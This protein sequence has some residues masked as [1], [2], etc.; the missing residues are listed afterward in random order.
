MKQIN[1]IVQ[2]IPGLSRNYIPCPG[3][4]REINYILCLGERGQNHTLSRGT[5]PNRPYKGVHPTGSV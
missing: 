3:Q 4:T 1:L 2:T 5:S